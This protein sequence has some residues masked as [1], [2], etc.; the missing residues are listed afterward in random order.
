MRRIIL[1]GNWKMNKTIEESISFGKCLKGLVE[2]YPAIIIFPPFMSI[3]YLNEVLKG[4][5]ISLGAQNMYFEAKGAFTGEISPLMIKDA[6]AKY[7]LIGHSERRHIFGEDDDLIAMKISAAIRNE[8]TPILCVGETLYER[9]NN[10]TN[11][12]V[13]RQLKIGLSQISKSSNFI[14]AYEPVWA[15]GTGINATPEQ[16]SLV[17]NHIRNIL[18]KLFGEGVGADITI[19]YGGSV[20][21]D[22]I[23]NLAR[24][25]DIDGALVGGASLE[26]ETFASLCKKVKSIKI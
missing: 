12:V 7:V 22:N 13:E 19:L 17:H 6:G 20:N 16:A 2:D 23:G 26:C 10:L 3:S 25:E 18:D 24:I 5:K 8:I 15:I 11:S 1:A 9:Q 21:I 4:T 14:I